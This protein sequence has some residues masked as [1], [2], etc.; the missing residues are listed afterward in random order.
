MHFTHHRSRLILDYSSFR[1]TPSINS[2]GR[3]Q[4]PDSGRAYAHGELC[5][6]TVCMHRTL[7]KLLQANVAQQY[8]LPVPLDFRGPIQDASEVSSRHKLDD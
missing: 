2:E 7:P 8:L 5:Y 4:G 1:F 3:Q 6:A